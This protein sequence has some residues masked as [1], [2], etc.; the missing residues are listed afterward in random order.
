[1]LNIQKY[2]EFKPT[3]NQKKK[4]QII[5]CHT[6]REVGEYL[7]SLKFR[8]NG[9]FDRIPNYVVTREGKVLQLLSNTS[10]TNYFPDENVNRNS[11]IICLENLGWLE[12]K[13]LSNS[14]INWKGSIYNEQ[15]TT[16][17]QYLS[18]QLFP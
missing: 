8:Y 2:G 14:Y 18:H 12:K 11:V 17:L 10:H 1:M 5:L 7:S 9:S 16:T 15:V 6:S 13:P 3:G 4:K